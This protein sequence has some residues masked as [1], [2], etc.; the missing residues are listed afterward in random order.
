[1]LARATYLDSLSVEQAATNAAV[2]RLMRD[3][4]R[5]EGEIAQLIGRKSVMPEAEY[6][7]Q[8]EKLFIELA[9]VN[10]AIKQGAASPTEE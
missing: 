6:E 3:R 10:R 4:T 5:L 1:M 8:L 7:T 9:K 2:A